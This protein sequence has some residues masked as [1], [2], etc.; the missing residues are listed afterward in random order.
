M[1]NVAGI[2][3]WAD[4]GVVQESLFLCKYQLFNEIFQNDL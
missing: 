1:M 2:I 4:L 3:F